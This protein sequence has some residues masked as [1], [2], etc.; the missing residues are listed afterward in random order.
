MKTLSTKAL[1]GL[2]VNENPVNK[3]PDWVYLSIKILSTKTLSTKPLMYCISAACLVLFHDTEPLF[4]DGGAPF[5]EAARKPLELLRVNSGRHKRRRVGNRNEAGRLL[6]HNRPSRDSRG[7]DSSRHLGHNRH[8][9][10]RFNARA[11]RLVTSVTAVSKTVA[12]LRK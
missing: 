12:N 5:D 7:W 8:R 6:R 4:K 9:L 1:I 11:L 3:N 10:S 2:F